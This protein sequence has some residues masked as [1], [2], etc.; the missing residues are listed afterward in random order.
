[1]HDAHPVGDI[2]LTPSAVLLPLVLQ[3]NAWH[4]LFIRRT[5]TVSH[6]KG[7]IAFPGGRTESHDANPLATALR[8]TKEELGLDPQQI[9]I[10]GKLPPTPTT[11]TGFLIHPFV[12]ILPMEFQ[13]HPDPREVADTLMVPLRFFLE[14]PA[15]VWTNA[16]YT[17][18]NEIIWGATAKITTL[19][20]VCL[21]TE[22]PCAL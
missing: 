6:H 3:H 20:A 9:R 14:T 18:Q 10:L 1:M 12:G 19:L 5:M 8:E 16:R 22:S 17:Y 4:L 13:L 2:P 11:Q 15:P 21:L 7:Q